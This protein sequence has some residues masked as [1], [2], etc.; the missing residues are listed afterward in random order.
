MPAELTPEMLSEIAAHPG[1]AIRVVD[2]TGGQTFFLVSED[3]LTHLEA[4]A[5]EQ[6]TAT[7]DRLRELISE[8]DAS[9]EVDASVVYDELMRRANAIDSASA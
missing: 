7:L 5:A 3:R 2:A 8:G 4:V 1:E 6:S 9:S